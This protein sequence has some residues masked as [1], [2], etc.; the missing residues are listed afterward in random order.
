MFKSKVRK[1]GLLNIALNNIL[2]KTDMVKEMIKQDVQKICS[3]RYQIPKNENFS[4]Y[5]PSN[6]RKDK[7]V[8]SIDDLEDIPNQPEGN[9]SKA[10]KQHSGLQKLAGTLKQKI[11]ARKSKEQLDVQNTPNIH[12]IQGTTPITDKP[13]NDILDSYNYG[14]D[15]VEPS[16]VMKQK[17]FLTYS[18]IVGFDSAPDI[19]ENYGK[20]DDADDEF[21]SSP[22]MVTNVDGNPIR[23]SDDGLS[24]GTKSSLNLAVEVSQK[25]IEK[26]QH[27]NV[28]SPSVL[29]DDEKSK[30]SASLGSNVSNIGYP[31]S[32]VPIP[33]SSPLI[34]SKNVSSLS[35]P[36]KNTGSSNSTALSSPA[37]GNPYSSAEVTLR[38]SSKA[39]YDTNIQIPT[40]VSQRKSAFGDVFKLPFGAKT[41]SDYKGNDANEELSY[42]KDE[43]VQVYPDQTKTLYE[44]EW[45]WA[46]SATAAGYI[47]P[48]WVIRLKPLPPKRR[49]TREI[50]RM[51]VPTVIQC[52]I[53]YLSN[54]TALTSQGLFRLSG[55]IK[56][57][58]QLKESFEYGILTAIPSNTD[59]NEVAGL[60]KMSL[61]ENDEVTVPEHMFEE[62]ERVAG[63]R[64]Q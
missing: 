17:D 55:N 37:S 25:Q 31:L 10:K 14:P 47:N 5:Q 18:N 24:L 12:I 50:A 6:D 15:D 57:I 60:L 59:V 20:A 30:D 46:I 42:S 9:L 8:K 40:P 22:N 19:Y 21:N 34:A 16:I 56:S 29:A 53:D 2:F 41:L 4:E 44:S 54:D 7:S 36:T 51:Y 58:K 38:N 35:N 1:H 64:K 26:K 28:L 61:R 33:G 39:S 3:Y 62:L 32:P 45:H 13:V 43:N 23:L 49:N 11:G 27:A 63:N 52:C 48:K